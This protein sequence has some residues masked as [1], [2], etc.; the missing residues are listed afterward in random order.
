MTILTLLSLFAGAQDEKTAWDNTINKDWP[1]GFQAV[2]IQSS[3]D[4]TQQKAVFHSS[5]ENEAQPLIVSLHTWSGDYLQKDPLADE[6]LLRGWNYIHPDFRG[7]NTKPEACGS[8]KVIPDIEDVI[9]YAIEHGN[10]DT[11][12]VHIIGVSGGGY[13]TLLAFM[14]LDYPVKS[15][16]AWAS[17]SNLENW[18]WECK[19]RGLKYAGHLEQVTTNGNGFDVAEARNRSPLFVSFQSEKR[20]GASLN[21]YAGIHDGYTG[22][23]PISHSI[24]MYNKLID[25]MYPEKA[26]EKISESQAYSL[27]TKQIN[28]EAEPNAMI[29]GRQIELRKELP[30]LTFTLFDGTHEMLVPQALPLIDQS[31]NSTSRAYKVLTI[32]DSNG[33]FPY[34]WTQQLKKLLPFSTIVNRS[35]AGNTIGFDNL[36]REELNTLRNITRYLDE[37]YA[38]L[39]E[40]EEF[41]YLFINLGTN[42]TKTIF[43]KRQKEVYANF[44][45]LIGMI[46][47]YMKEHGK[48]VP[49]ICWVSPSPMD[50]AK[51]N[52]VKYDGGDQRIQI[53]NKKFE[54]LAVRDDI[55]FLNTYWVLKPGFESKTEDGV[56]LKAAAQFRLASEIAKWI[57]QQ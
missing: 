22:S 21:I 10:V 54:K 39:G 15:F 49:T 33:T 56:H 2:D 50:A 13:A 53:N 27:L 20:K 34:S 16:N 14:K 1:E 18:Y 41:D 8:E 48:T 4:G 57:D 52:P 12:E 19:G 7:S 35:I 24:D 17:I 9:H 23:V 45:K 51:A 25:D 36:D 28:P 3:V 55:N 29:G 5:N 31:T 11:T 47:N 26:G 37:A 32:G 42:D 38:E 40:E 46:R 44:E 6:I 43:A 30:G